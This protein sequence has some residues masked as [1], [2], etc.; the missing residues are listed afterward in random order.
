MTRI[1]F[2]SNVPDKFVYACRLVRKARGA[3]CRIVLLTPD[4]STLMALDQQ[5]WTFSEQDF[6]PHVIAGDPLAANTPV[7]LTDQDDADLPHHQILINLSART[8]THFARFERMFEIISATDD[9][10]IAGRER[11]RYYQQRGYPLTHFVADKA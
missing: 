1:D 2:H 3:N 6:L 11:Y 5:L 10:K 4:K 9:D 7:I 8:P